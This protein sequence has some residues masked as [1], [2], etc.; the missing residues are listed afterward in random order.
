VSSG[1]YQ[2]H[3]AAEWRAADAETRKAWRA[4]ERKPRA[5]GSRDQERVR[6]GESFDIVHLVDATG[7]RCERCGVG[8]EGYRPGDRISGV[9]PRATW[10]TSRLGPRCRVAV[11]AP[12]VASSAGDLIG[13]ED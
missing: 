2:N 12:R 8:L 4:E 5:A 9:P 3:S 13:Q 6:D 1:I 11:P 10:R 7:R